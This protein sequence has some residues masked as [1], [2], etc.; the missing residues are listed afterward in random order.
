MKLSAKCVAVRICPRIYFCGESISKNA[1]RW[2]ESVYRPEMMREQSSARKCIYKISKN[3]KPQDTSASWGRRKLHLLDTV[4]RIFAFGEISRALR[5]VS[6]LLDLR[7]GKPNR[8]RSAELRGSDEWG[9]I[10]ASRKGTPMACLF[11]WLGW[12]DSNRRLPEAKSGDL[13]LGDIP[14]IYPYIVP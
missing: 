9:T 13:P 11:C 4:G 8:R 14:K 6:Q 2:F 10:P 3:F 5:L 12:P 1:F 7:A